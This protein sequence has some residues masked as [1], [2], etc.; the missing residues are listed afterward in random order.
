MNLFE[1]LRRNIENVKR[2]ISDIITESMVAEKEVIIDL[3]VD[4][5]ER[6]INSDGKILGE[7]E[8][9]SY[10][11]LKQSMG[12]RAPF[13]VFDFKLEGDFLSGIY[14]EA[15]KGSTPEASGLYMSSSDEKTEK[16]ERLSGDKVFGIAP[17]NNNELDELT[18]DY[19]IQEV[20]NEITDI[21]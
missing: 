3:N 10:S 13:G 5:I 4:Q 18:E 12:S 8:S 21:E 20:I 15:Y 9:E 11:R 14:A 6:G 1:E 17:E 7:Y 16:L 19:I 2:N